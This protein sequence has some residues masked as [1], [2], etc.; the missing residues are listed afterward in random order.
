MRGK[1]YQIMHRSVDKSAGENVGGW[2]VDG[3]MDGKGRVD[4]MAALQCA[5]NIVLGLEGE[6]D[7]QL[8]C[9]FIYTLFRWTLDY[10]IAFLIAHL[11]N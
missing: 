11:Y 10:S 1:A 4:T 6:S 2:W 9:I 3:W 8:L 7:L 5:K